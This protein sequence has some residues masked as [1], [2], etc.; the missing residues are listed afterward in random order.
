VLPLLDAARKTLREA[1][2]HRPTAAA[3]A[4][5]EDARLVQDAKTIALF[6]LGVADARYA[7]ELEKQQEIVMNLSDIFMETFAMESTLLRSRKLGSSRSAATSAAIRSI[8]LRDA[9]ARIQAAAQAIM[10]AC[11]AGGDLHRHMD[12]LR[13]LAQHDPV[14]A[15]ALR[16]SIAQELLGSERY[17]F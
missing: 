8:F 10:G 5:A 2:N 11:S 1:V 6:T 15:I 17:L 14:N 12:V 9:M 3:D 4:G 16:R 7:A 13:T